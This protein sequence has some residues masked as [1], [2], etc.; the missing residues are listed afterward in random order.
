[1]P[2]VIP[3][4]RLLD[5]LCSAVH[6]TEGEI[7][8]CAACPHPSSHLQT[9]LHYVHTPAGDTAA[10]CMAAFSSQQPDPAQKYIIKKPQK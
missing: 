8:V 3:A 1:M 2:K 5:S 9:C 6:T 7:P 10:V 4:E